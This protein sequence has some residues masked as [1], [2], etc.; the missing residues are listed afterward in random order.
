[1]HRCLPDAGTEPGLA[2]TRTS[3]CR[4]LLILLAAVIAASIGPSRGSKHDLAQPL[5]LEPGG[6]GAQVLRPHAGVLW[7]NP[8]SLRK[9]SGGA[10]PKAA[11]RGEYPRA[12]VVAGSPDAPELHPQR[13]QSFLSCRTWNPRDPPL[14][15]G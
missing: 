12:V 1:M 3:A 7:R 5:S 14:A 15:R 13:H 11:S 2:G 6:V 4:I 8:S 9:E 10:Q